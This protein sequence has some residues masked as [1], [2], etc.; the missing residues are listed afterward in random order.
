[1]SAA[2]SMTILTA[3]SVQLKKN[4]GQ[5]VVEHVHEIFANILLEG[6]DDNVPVMYWVGETTREF[7]QV[8]LN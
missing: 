3:F 2:E 7:C 5:M 8:L 6:L 1:M 4:V